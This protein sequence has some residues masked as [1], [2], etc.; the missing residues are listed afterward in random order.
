MADFLTMAKRFEA[1]D[2]DFDSIILDIIKTE[3]GFILDLVRDEQLYQGLKHTGKDIRPKYTPTTKAIK[4][5][6][7]QPTDRVT[8]KDTGD[9]YDSLIIEYGQNEIGIRALDRKIGKLV[10]KYGRDV[11]GLT[12]DSIDKVRV[13]IKDKVIDTFRQ[14]LLN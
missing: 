8:W 12:D 14:K 13:Q 6:K 2:K 7:G 11:L 5:L 1:V 10:A 4:R 9:L 3:E